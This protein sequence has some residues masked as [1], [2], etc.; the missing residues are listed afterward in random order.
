MWKDAQLPDEDAAEKL[1]LRYNLRELAC[2]FSQSI[3]NG[4]RIPD[5]IYIR[6]LVFSEIV[7]RESRLGALVAGRE[8][9]PEKLVLMAVYSRFLYKKEPETLSHICGKMFLLLKYKNFRGGVVFIEP[10]FELLL[11]RAGVLVAERPQEISP[12][13]EFSRLEVQANKVFNAVARWKALNTT[14]PQ[15]LFHSIQRIRRTRRKQSF[16]E[17]LAE[18]E[19]AIQSTSNAVSQPQPVERSAQNATYKVASAS[20]LERCLRWATARGQ[21]QIPKADLLLKI[22]PPTPTVQ[23]A[24]RKFISWTGLPPVQAKSIFYGFL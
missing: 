15:T 14:N 16:A 18:L 17:F 7:N 9:L 13:V 8:I 4:A 3:P 11:S 20:L 2:V 24:L 10:A 5:L 6:G 21:R 12:E 22:R 19:S 1:R 23:L